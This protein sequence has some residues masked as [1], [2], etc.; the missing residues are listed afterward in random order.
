MKNGVILYSTRHDAAGS[1]PG[2]ERVLWPGS[3]QAHF[4]DPVPPAYRR[5]YAER[6]LPGQLHE[7]SDEFKGPYRPID[8]PKVLGSRP[9][10]NDTPN[11]EQCWLA[12]EEFAL[13]RELLATVKQASDTI[14]R[15]RKLP[16]GTAAIHG[17]KEIAVGDGARFNPRGVVFP[18]LFRAIP[19]SKGKDNGAVN[20]LVPR[21]YVATDAVA[22]RLPVAIVLVVDREFIYDV[23]VALSDSP[24]LLDFDI[25]TG[26]GPIRQVVHHSVRGSDN[27]A[28]MLI[29]AI[30][31]LYERYPPRRRHGG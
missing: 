11:D 13:R 29:Y 18:S 30:A 17:V 27:L 15:S 31:P 28:E 14:R 5:A 20:G 24:V 2:G 25:F 22:R 16:E 3:R 12:Q 10:W 19:F 9:A 8:L 6:F 4:G 1:R 26:R 23:L 21:R 7:A